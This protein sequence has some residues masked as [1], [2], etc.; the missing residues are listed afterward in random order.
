MSTLPTMTST[1]VR[2]AM[3]DALQLDLI[4]PSDDAAKPLGNRTET[5]EQ[6]PSR[7]YLTGFLVPAGASAE[8][9][10]DPSAEDDLDSGEAGGFDDDKPTDK[11]G[12]RDRVMPSSMGVSVILPP[13]TKAVKVRA[14]WGDYR[15]EEAK[16]GNREGEQRAERG[17]TGNWVRTP[18]ESFRE[19]VLPVGNA[20]GAKEY[21]LPNSG[22]LAVA[23]AVRSILNPPAES[24]LP[25]GAR[26]V[27]VFLVNRRTPVPDIV[28]DTANAFQAVLVLQVETEFLR[29]PDLRGLTSED[30][31][32]KLADLQYRDLGEY[33]V[34]HNV[35]T[36]AICNGEGC[37]TVETVWLPQSAVE[38]VAAS[39]VEGVVLEMD[40]LG[41]EVDAAVLQGRLMPLVT[42][43]REWIGGQRAGLS[44]SGAG[45]SARR[46]ETA[47]KL[48]Q[49]ADEVAAVRIAGG[50]ALLADADCRLAFRMAN[51]AMAQAARQRFGVMNGVDPA[52]I[53]PKWRLFQLAFLLMN[54]AGIAEPGSKEREVVDLLFFPTGGGK[55]EAYL[56]LAAF[57]MLLRRLKNPGVCG[58]GVSVLMRY[59]LRLLTLDQ[60]GRAATLVCALELMRQQRV[61]LWG[62]W[63]FEIGLW[64]GRAATPNRMG[65]VGIRDDESA[66]KRTSDY[67]N[68]STKPSPIP[69]ESCPWCGQKFSSNS[70]VLRPDAKNP[71][72]LWMTCLNP[73]CAFSRGKF[74]PM[75]TVDEPLYRR[76]PCFLIATVDKFAGLPWFGDTGALF[77]RVDRYDPKFGFFGPMDPGVGAPIPGGRLPPPDLIVQDELHLISGPL[78]TLAGLYETTIEELCLRKLDGV[79]VRPKII[80]STATVRR[81]ERQIRALFNRREVDVFPP[82]GPNRRDSFFAHT[83]TVRESP[84]RLY[85]GVAAQGRSPKLIM[86]LV[87]QTLL[88]ASQYLWERAGGA[89]NVKNP[90]DPYMTMVGYFN[91]LRELGGARRI[92]E[93]ELRN[94]LLG[95]S[96]R[97]RV[98][99]P[100]DGLADRKIDYDPVELTSRESTA[101]VSAAK[102]RLER[103]FHQD[104]PVHVAIATN[105]I[106]VGLD[107]PRLGMMA[108][109]GQPKTT[110]EYIQATSRV[111][112]EKEKPGLVVTLFNIHK[113]RDRSHYER[114]AYSHETF[115]RAVEASSVTPFS[116]RALDKGLAGALVGLARH[117]LS[118]MTASGAAAEI[119]KYSAQLDP[120][121]EAFAARAERQCELGAAEATALGDK[122]RTRARDLL[123]EWAKEEMDLEKG[124]TK[125]R[126]AQEA[127]AGKP[128]IRDFLDKEVVGLPAGHRWR[129]FRA[130]RS[131]RDVELTA[132]VY[133]RTLENVVVEDES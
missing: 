96:K 41:E 53:Q 104:E 59:T 127:T 115:Y 109:F 111:G 124:N 72:D 50:I 116:P 112:R 113:P 102:R 54:L 57:T 75:V 100:A 87:Y 125:L 101:K 47:E 36:R 37:H 97:C 11:A 42:Q 71:T 70:F 31:D 27:S 33:A 79:V 26:T 106:S 76:L 74:L 10:T 45:L 19:L 16:A 132:A 38:R 93:D 108:V 73:K 78:G 99:Q 48:L 130:G 55:T 133:V 29:R 68:D 117:G 114:F 86:L 30:R 80:A 103:A 25:T 92:V 61:D 129:K 66:R 63:P 34:G 24:G 105:M 126:Y 77:G 32:E 119:V 122:V 120:V 23:L 107:I 131:L 52:T 98:G 69:V 88:S 20:G 89:K 65:G 51:Q 35:A 85:L 17:T 123:T 62:E 110:A 28:R 67:K 21:P 40:V 22:G 9:R 95:Y 18:R 128:L 90:A 8:D 2:S 1:E 5:L 13:A 46:R 84:A 58:A 91:A 12:A 39:E 64:V 56:G 82:P 83:Q 6:T 49:R 7:W 60:L 4:G 81:A 3:V 15:P 121:V 118:A 44:A 14:T 43:Y 94:G